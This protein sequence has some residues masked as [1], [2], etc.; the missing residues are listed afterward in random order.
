MI[1]WMMMV[2]GRQE[3]IQNVSMKA[4]VSLT[5]KMI[6]IYFT[7]ENTL[8]YSCVPGYAPD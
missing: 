6:L 4:R 8:R 2:Q 3:G 5:M 1:D 7:A